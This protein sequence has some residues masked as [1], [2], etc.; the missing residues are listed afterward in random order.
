MN[1]IEKNNLIK[2]YKQLKL[3]MDAAYDVFRRV[4]SQAA[5]VRY[6]TNTHTFKT[7]CTEAMQQF[8]DESPSSGLDKETIL[9]NFDSYRICNSCLKELLFRTQSDDF[10]ATLDF[11]Q[12]FPG[13]CFTCQVDY[14]VEQ[15]CVTCSENPE[16]EPDKCPFKE[17]KNIY[18]NDN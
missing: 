13:S 1:T 18:L 6:H 12:E 16:S 10:V 8:A 5:A 2:K 7:F 4:P 3:R 11:I 14:C 15:D 9:A 17:I